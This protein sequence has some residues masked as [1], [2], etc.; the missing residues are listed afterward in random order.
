MRQVRLI[1]DTHHIFKI[2]TQLLNDIQLYILCLDHFFVFF[3][4]RLTVRN[5]SGKELLPVLLNAK[6]HLLRNGHECMITHRSAQCVD[7]F[8][9]LRSAQLYF[10][11]GLMVLNGT[12][13]NLY[14]LKAFTIIT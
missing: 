9:A 4:L 7:H 3:K 5:Q 2:L 8:N 6:G 10:L 13:I 14:S 12:T 11:H 1:S